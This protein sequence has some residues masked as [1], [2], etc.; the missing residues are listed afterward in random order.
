LAG[1]ETEIDE[2]T[3]NHVA[4]IIDGHRKWAKSRGVTVQEGHQTGVNNWKHIISRASQL[5][6]KLLT[7]WALSPQNFNRSKMEVDFLM[8]IYEDFLRSDVKE[9]VTSQQDIQFSAI[10]DKSRLPEY[11]QD[12]I[13]YAE[14]LSQANKGMHFILA[15]AYGGREDIVEAARKIAAKVEHGILRP[16]DI[17]EATFEQHLMTNITKFPSPDLLIRAAGEQR[18]SN[19]FLWQLPFTEFYFTPK[20]FPDFGEAD[21]LDA[22]ASYRC[23]YRGFGERKGIHEASAWSHPQFE[24]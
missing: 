2:V 23:R 4:I 19:F 11:L 24:K 16:D 18:L 1:A 14:G 3:P 7:I 21:L 5:G 12:A 13:S 15:V 6:I 20:L 8:R 9:L 10:G 17:D 22:L